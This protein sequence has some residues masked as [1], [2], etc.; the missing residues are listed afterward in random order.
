M[1]CRLVEQAL[2]TLNSCPMFT[3]NERDL[4]RMPTPA[5]THLPIKPFISDSGILDEGSAA[6]NEV[7]LA[8]LH[9]TLRLLFLLNATL[10]IRIPF[11]LQA[12]IALLRLPAPSLRGT[13]AKAYSLLTRLVAQI[14]WDELLRSRSAV[15]VMEEEY[16]QQKNKPDGSTAEEPLPNGTASSATPPSPTSSSSSS[17]AHSQTDSS[18]TQAMR[19]PGP[20]FPG[21]TNTSSSST[22]SSSLQLDAPGQHEIPTIKISSESD[23]DEEHRDLARAG[24]DVDGGRGEKEKLEGVK[25][26]DSGK[27]EE[28]DGA[29]TPTLEKPELARDPGEGGGGDAEG[30]PP[31]PPGSLK[32]KEK[33]TSGGDDGEVEEQEG[34]SFSSKRYAYLALS[35]CPHLLH[36][37]IVLAFRLCRLCERWLDNLF[38][39]LYEVRLFPSSSLRIFLPDP[40]VAHASSDRTGSACLHHLASR[41]LAFQDPTYVS[42]P[43]SFVSSK[44]PEC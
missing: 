41:D 39:V 31:S 24:V 11:S 18:S 2:L 35:G 23:R 38:M 33:Q 36:L 19:S 27:G 14:G 21:E 26:E 3:Y 8:S 6:D 25:E 42:S 32:G 30:R 34:F 12:D 7:S 13:F 10:L 9:P 20:A 22:T 4:H 40:C 15:F 16:R 17:S 37:L 43:F 1:R 29:K 44:L 28:E 5:R